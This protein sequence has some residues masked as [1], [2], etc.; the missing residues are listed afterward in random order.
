MKESNVGKVDEVAVYRGVQLGGIGSWNDNVNSD[1][2]AF[3]GVVP[4]KYLC[5]ADPNM[6]R[7]IYRAMLVQQGVSDPPFPKNPSY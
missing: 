4:A 5:P 7:P 3:P 2:R 1:R 6:H